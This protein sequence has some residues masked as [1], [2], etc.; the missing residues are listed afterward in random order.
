M[1]P[2]ARAI[3]KSWLECGIL[4]LPFLFLSPWLEVYVLC[5]N[6]CEPETWPDFDG[7][8]DLQI[9]LCGFHAELGELL[10][11]AGGDGLLSVTTA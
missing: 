11:E 5:C 4:H 10:A 3:Q 8:L 7:G 6:H 1:I 9:S 2:F